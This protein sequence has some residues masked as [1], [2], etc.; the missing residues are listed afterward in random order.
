MP[1][2]NGYVPGWPTWAELA[3]PDIQA[4]NDFYCGLFG[5]YAYTVTFPGLADYQ[6]FTLGDVQGPEV[7]GMLALADDAQPAS[8]TC[9]FRTE[10]LRKSLDTVTRLGGQT[11]MPPTDVSNLGRMALCS[12]L[13]GADFAFWL[14]GTLKGAG[15]A[16]E[17]STMCWVELACH[18]LEG[19]RR[20]YG[21]VFG[22]RSVERDYSPPYYTNFKVG[23]WS[24]AGMVSLDVLRTAGFPPHWIPYFWVEDCDASAARAAELGARVRIP[25]TDIKPGRFA[26]MTDPTGARLAIV[27]PEPGDRA[28]IRTRP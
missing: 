6:I 26:M 25:P 15:V 12:D 14:P 4:S 22:W 20:F 13:E 3:S 28:A 17:P 2:V 9:Y 21:E 5:W 1:E 10:D 23:D 8:W 19:A 16:D 7:A 11:L 24:V 27:T 18:D